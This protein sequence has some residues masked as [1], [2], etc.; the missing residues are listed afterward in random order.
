MGSP[1]YFKT[2]TF[3]KKLYRLTADQLHHWG[4]AEK[5]GQREKIARKLTLLAKW[6]KLTEDVAHEHRTE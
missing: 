4:E 5:L 6:G 1:A 3:G 2:V